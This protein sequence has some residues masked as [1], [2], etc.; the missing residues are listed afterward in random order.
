MLTEV[1]E[2]SIRNFPLYFRSLGLL[3]GVGRRVTYWGWDCDRDSSG[4]FGFGGLTLWDSCQ[5]LGV[6]VGSFGK[7]ALS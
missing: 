5:G 1:A 7:L 4:K 3:M 6:V 2:D